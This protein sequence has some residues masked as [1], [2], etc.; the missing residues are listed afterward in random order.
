MRNLTDEQKNKMIA[1]TM[2][3]FDFAQAQAIMLAMDWK[4]SINMEGYRTP[5]VSEIEN[6]CQ[7]M[8]RQVMG[9]G[10]KS[11]QYVE[12]GGFQAIWWPFNNG[13]G[14]L[15]LVFKPVKATASTYFVG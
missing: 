10:S 5:T 14:E 1:S 9:M 7:S 6:E 13:E 12:C 15:E 4:W 3:S 2:Q 11:Y 8:L